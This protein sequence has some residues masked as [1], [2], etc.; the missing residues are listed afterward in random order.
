MFLVSFCCLVSDDVSAEQ[1]PV[2]PELFS[3]NEYG[4][5]FSPLAEGYNCAAGAFEI[6]LGTTAPQYLSDLSFCV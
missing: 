4:A 6:H 3:L 1:T 5:E 2:T